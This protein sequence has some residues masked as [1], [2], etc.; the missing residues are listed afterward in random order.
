[1]RL[2]LRRLI[3][4]RGYRILGATESML[5]ADENGEGIIEVDLGGRRDVRVTPA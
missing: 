4:H 2:A 3:P 1:M 5:V